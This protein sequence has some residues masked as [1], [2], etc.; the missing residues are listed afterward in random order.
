MTSNILNWISIY[1]SNFPM[2]IAVEEGM[3][4]K[5]RVRDE[6]KE[7][8]SVWLLSEGGRMEWGILMKV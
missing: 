3:I 7:P 1:S 8:D 6:R 4:V 5:K 2:N